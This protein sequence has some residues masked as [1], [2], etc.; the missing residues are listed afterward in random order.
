M[1]G[2]IRTPFPQ[3]ADTPI[4]P[5]YAQDARGTILLDPAYQEGLTD[6]AG[7]ERIWLLYWLDRAPAP[8]L[9]VKPFLDQHEHGIFATRSPCRPNPIGLSCVRLLEV[10]GC[11]L[12]VADVD[13]VDRTPLLDIKPYVPDFDVY[14][15]QHCGW[16][17]HCGANLT[18]AD[19]RFAI[20]PNPL[21]GNLE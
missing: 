11:E 9:M 8:R 1:I 4:Q 13:I 10:C 2:V 5:R 14:S 21:E 12:R 16:F 20:A 19:D 3:P 6:L 17:N 18:R 7:F 15:V